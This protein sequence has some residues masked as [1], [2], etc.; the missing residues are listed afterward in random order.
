[1]RTLT[2]GLEM[3]EQSEDIFNAFKEVAEATGGLVD[4]SADAAY[5]FQQA[6]YAA[7]YYDLLYGTPKSDYQDGEFRRIAVAVKGEKYRILHRA[8]YLAN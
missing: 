5:A 7:E 6:V 1:L 2:S 8:G 3:R 4:N